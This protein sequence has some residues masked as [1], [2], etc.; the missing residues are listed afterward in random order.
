MLFCLIPSS[1]FVCV[2]LFKFSV[3]LFAIWVIF[4]QSYLEHL[5]FLLIFLKSYS[6]A[7]SS[8]ILTLIPKT[9]APLSSC[10]Q[11]CC[12]KACFVPLSSHALLSLETFRPLSVSDSLQFHC[13]RL[14]YEFFLNSI[15]CSVGLCN[16][17]AFILFNSENLSLLFPLC[18]NHFL[19]QV[20]LAVYILYINKA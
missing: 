20:L 15:W 13:N 6:S 12:W 1:S 18:F 14:R 11:C 10:R 2:L 3:L 16:L 9:I 4:S 5:L 8:S 19:L 7:F 17:R